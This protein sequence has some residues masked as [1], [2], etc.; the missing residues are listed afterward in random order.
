M[1]TF[2]NNTCM[3]SFDA[4]MIVVAFISYLSPVII[5]IFFNA[6][7]VDSQLKCETASSFD[8]YGY[9]VTFN[10]VCVFNDRKMRSQSAQ[11]HSHTPVIIIFVPLM[12]T[13]VYI[14]Y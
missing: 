9:S 7:L 5:I 12:K 11:T 1:L 10:T 6:L 13:E 8:S 3:F 14:Q 2:Q 4:A